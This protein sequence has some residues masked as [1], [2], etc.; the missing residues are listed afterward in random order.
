MPVDVVITEEFSETATTK[1]VNI[2]SIPSNWE[3]VDID[4]KTREIY[5]D[6]IKNSKL[7]VWNDQWVYSK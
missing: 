3:G 6:V 7:V 1:I 2:D 4:H 5:A